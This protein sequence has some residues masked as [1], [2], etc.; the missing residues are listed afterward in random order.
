MK[1]RVGVLGA[2]GAVGQRFVQLLEGHPWFELAAVVASERSAG[3]PYAEACS[4]KLDTPMPAAARGLV[5]QPLEPR[6]DC[7]LVFSALDAAV[8]GPAEEAFA[9]AGH[10]VLSNARNHRMDDDV[11][12][13]VPEV[14][15][16]HASLIRIQRKKRGWR[17][18]IATNPNCAT[19]T[20]V[21]A[22]A[23]LERRFGLKAVAVTT[24]QAISG[25]GYPG[26]PSLDILGNVI[27]FIAG[28]EEKIERE[29]RKILGAL[30]GDRVA[31]H[32]AVVSATTTRVPV[33]DG[34][35]AS[36][37]ATLGSDPGLDAVCEAIR[38]H[39]SVPQDRQLPSAPAHPTLLVEEH[40]R[41]QP[42]LDVN[43][44]KGMASIVGRVRRC[45][46]MG[47]KFVVLGHNTIR[48]AA[49]AAILNAELLKSEGLLEA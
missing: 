46:L 49:G 19:A 14:N 8:A 41:P 31:P 37:F 16:D 29:T 3:K 22:L 1:I 35:T 43:R 47:Y 25:A 10:A 27:P 24:L 21:L 13:L 9:A 36:V 23:P 17:G 44:E 32:S 7:Q 42:R 26:L 38:T 45:E 4:W 40:D 33:V 18:F 15:P 6:L 11:P 39:R 30:G 5:V 12:L 2:T 28:E 48:G 20:L 34:H